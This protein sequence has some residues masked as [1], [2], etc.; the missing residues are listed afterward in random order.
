MKK[1]YIKPIMNVVAC[2]PA[3]IMAGSPTAEVQKW[4]NQL[5]RESDDRFDWGADDEPEEW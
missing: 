5:S 1:V 2:S 3:R 4:D